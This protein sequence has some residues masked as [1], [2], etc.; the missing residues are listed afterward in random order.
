MF[1]KRAKRKRSGRLG[2]LCI[3]CAVCS[4]SVAEQC[5][6]KCLKIP[7]APS[8]TDFRCSPA[9]KHVG[10]RKLQHLRWQLPLLL[11]DWVT[12]ITS[13]FSAYSFI[14]FLPEMV[15]GK[16]WGIALPHDPGFLLC[17]LCTIQA[18]ENKCMR[19]CSL[20][21]N[22]WLQMLDLY[23]MTCGEPCAIGNSDFLGSD[24]HGLFGSEIIIVTLARIKSLK[25]L[26]RNHFQKTCTQK[27]ILYIC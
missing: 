22:W 18:P 23:E 2:M 16:K 4:I 19:S 8:D 21:Q 15:P 5:A 17:L 6:P 1:P 3:A 25:R 13:C 11:P 12:V 9:S 26:C 24:I 10:V 20:H 27:K 14:P 7:C